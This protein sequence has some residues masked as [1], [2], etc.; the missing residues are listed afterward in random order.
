MARELKSIGF[1]FRA[2][3]V[4]FPVMAYDADA[5]WG[6][7][8]SVI[9]TGVG[10]RVMRPGLGTNVH[11]LLFDNITPILEARIAADIKRAVS[12]YVKSAEVL[13]VGVWKGEDQVQEASA[14]IV[15]II[16]RVS[17]QVFEQQIPVAAAG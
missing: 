2:G 10:E 15:K 12:L 17:N 11:A 8:K 13:S 6:H 4:S 1:P 16:W 3:T 14:V 5:V 7:I 9:L